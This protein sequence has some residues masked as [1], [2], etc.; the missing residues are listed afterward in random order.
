MENQCN[1]DHGSI[2]NC[3]DGTVQLLAIDFAKQIWNVNWVD[4]ETKASKIEL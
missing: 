2:I 3:M 1:S 4:G